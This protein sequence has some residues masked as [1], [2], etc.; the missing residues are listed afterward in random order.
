[1]IHTDEQVETVIVGTRHL[2]GSLSLARDTVFGKLATGRGIDVVA[3]LLG[4]GGS[5]FDMEVIGTSSL[6]DEVF[7]DELC[8]RAA[9]DITVTDEEDSFHRLVVQW[10]ILQ[11]FQGAAELVGTGGALG[12]TADAVKT[13]HDVVNMLAANELAD[14]LQVAVAASE[15]EYLLDDVV[16]VGCHINQL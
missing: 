7:H 11:L 14:A 4:G 10:C 5:R 13:L 1:M 2:T 16:F 8:H 3:N 9:A 12:A 15:E 6:A